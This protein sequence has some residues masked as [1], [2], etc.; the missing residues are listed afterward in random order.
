MFGY[1]GGVIGGG[2]GH[3]NWTI[4]N[5]HGPLY[6]SN[7]SGRTPFQDD[8]YNFIMQTPTING[9]PSGITKENGQHIPE[10]GSD[11]IVLEFEAQETIDHFGFTPFWKQFHNSVD[12]EFYALFHGHPEITPAKD[13]VRHKD[14]IAIGLLGLDIFEKATSELHP[15]FVLAIHT[16]EDPAD[17]T[18]AI[19]ARNYG[20]EGMCSDNMHY[21]DFN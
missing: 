11:P 17:D 14:A 6:W 8:D 15:V 4:V 10:L 13:M 20:N 5:Y 9:F 3:R 2:R 16:N 19:F 12:E 7:Y 18:W 1:C 21:A